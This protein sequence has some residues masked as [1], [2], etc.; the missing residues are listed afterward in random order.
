[1]KEIIQYQKVN[2]YDTAK[3]IKEW[4]DKLGIRGNS[5]VIDESGIGGGTVDALKSMGLNVI[6][7]IGAASPKRNKNY[8]N[9][10]QETF[11]EMPLHPLAI[12]DELKKKKWKIGNK[13]ES[14]WNIICQELSSIKRLPS[15]G[16][17]K[18]I[19]KDKIK[20]QIGRSPDLADAISLRMYFELQPKWGME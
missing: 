3:K 5:I 15:D 14:I 13:E 16:K 18:L 9:L 7:F 12:S 2:T 11:F 8:Q 17:P 10:R 4:A 20:S 6:G 19:S 1:M